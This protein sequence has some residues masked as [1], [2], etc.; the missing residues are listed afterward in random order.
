[1]NQSKVQSRKAFFVIYLLECV[2]GLSIGYYCYLRSAEAGAWVLVSTVMV[3]APDRSEAIKFALNRIKANLVGSAVG[4]LLAAIHPSNV[5]TMAAG[6]I[7]TAICCELLNLKNAMRSATVGVVLISLAPV[8]KAFY[9][10]AAARAACVILG[11]CLAMLLTMIMHVL[12]GNFYK[13]H[14][15]NKPR[16]NP[17]FSGDE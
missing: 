4:L 16:A 6:V 12:I 7:L 17:G 14:I 8:G 2:I 11:C 15:K 13:M 9:E 3:L 5:F 1:M 10:V